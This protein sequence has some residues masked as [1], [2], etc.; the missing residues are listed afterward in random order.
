MCFLGPPGAR[1]TEALRLEARSE[2]IEPATARDLWKLQPRPE[3]QDKTIY[4][5]GLDEARA[6]LADG[7]APFDGIR[8]RLQEL[9]CP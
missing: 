9:G 2:G 6:R 5:D 1:K 8:T 7:R 4:I 3:W